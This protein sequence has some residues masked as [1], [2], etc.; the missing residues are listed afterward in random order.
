MATVSNPEAL[1]V[2]Q[3]P[4]IDEVVRITSRRRGM[5]RE[6][7]EEFAATVRLRLVESDYRILRRFRGGSTLRTYLVTVVQRL[8]LDFVIRK[9]GKWRPS[10]KAR[11][12][13]PVAERLEQLLTRERLSL[14][15]ACRTMQ[16]D[17]QARLTRE[18]LVALATALPVRHRP[19]DVPLDEAG[20]ES[21]PDTPWT[22]LER[23]DPR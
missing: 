6:E 10:A 13:G 7:T 14:D 1:L 4:L 2:E 11:R 20:S 8:A 23:S 22:A 21:G 16:S 9:T 12:L 3:L 15:E 19:R 5:N 18:E 17:P